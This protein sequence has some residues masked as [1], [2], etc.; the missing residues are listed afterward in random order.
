LAAG[1]VAFAIALALDAPLLGFA[2]RTVSPRFA[3]AA[4][5]LQLLHR[6]A[7]VLGLGLG[8]LGPGLPPRRR[9]S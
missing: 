9:S 3:I 1:A 4:A 5:G 8:L 2:A 6:A 7:G